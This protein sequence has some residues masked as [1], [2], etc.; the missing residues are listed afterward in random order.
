MLNR[1]TRQ[2]PAHCGSAARLTPVSFS[3]SCHNNG[4]PA[5]QE[6]Q[7]MLRAARPHRFFRQPAGAI[8]GE[9]PFSQDLLST[10]RVIVRQVHKTQ[11][12]TMFGVFIGYMLGSGSR[13]SL[14][15]NR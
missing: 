14:I 2:F 9:R 6:T 5:S 1:T 13:S 4:I 7:R 8:P 3:S 11:G 15:H 10:D 12:D